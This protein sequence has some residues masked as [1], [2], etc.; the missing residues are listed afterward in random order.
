M[1]VVMDLYSR[2]IVG[3]AMAERMTATLV[4]DALQMALW[5]RKKP[6]G[7]ILHSDR[8]SQ[9][10]SHDDQRLIIKATPHCWHYTKQFDLEMP[11]GC[12]VFHRR[13]PITLP[14]D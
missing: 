4:M 13:V 12:L 2:L 8:G 1:A 6:R 14:T 5:R 3:W 10:C 7:V 9:Y 11:H